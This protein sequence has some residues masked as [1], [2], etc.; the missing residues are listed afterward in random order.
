MA[1][2]LHPGVFVEEV[3]SGSKPVEGVSTSVCGIVGI[4]KKGPLGEPILCSSWDD[5]ITVFGDYT[6]AGQLAYSAYGFFNNGGKSLYVVRTA[7]YATISQVTSTTAVASIATLSSGTYTTLKVEAGYRSFTSPGTHGDN[8]SITIATNS[9]ATATLTAAVGTLTTVATLST[10]EGIAINSVLKF[11]AAD[12][13]KVTAV[14]TT[15]KTVTFAAGLAATYTAASTVTSSEFDLTVLENS[16]TVETWPQLSMV[17]ASDNFVET[18]INN[19][20]TGSGYIKVTDLDAAI[21]NGLDNP[22]VGTTALASGADGTGS[23]AATDYIGDSSARNGMYALDDIDDINIVCIPDGAG[24]LAVTNAGL[25][26]CASRKDC[27]YIADMPAGKTPT[28]GKAFKDTITTNSYGALYYP[29]IYVNDP[30]SSTGTKKLVYPSGHIAGAYARIDNTRGVWK[31]P[32]GVEGVL[33]GALDIEYNVT[34]SEQDTL[35]PYGVNCIRNLK[36]IGVTIWGARTLSADA[37][38]KYVP[39]RRVF[40]YIEESILSGTNWAVFEPNNEN[41]WFKLSVSVSSFLNNLWKDGGLAGSKPSEAFY[42]K[43]DSSTNPQSSIDVGKVIMEI[44]VAPLKPA[45]FVVIRIGQW[46]G[47]KLV[48]EIA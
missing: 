1:G 44:G 3:S 35:N 32:A 23:L 43:C 34:D 47:G 12:F 41:L 22:A 26:Y 36:G 37:E 5:F 25:S 10:V 7:H 8:I 6:T 27:F 33:Y 24:V 13:R 4:A 21:G 18:V 29:L 38:W 40:E 17:D 15:N 30:L 45:E 14:D 19:P 20:T 9:K 42:V 16:I 39:V 31:A 48:Q 2:Y 11:A 28:T 46:D